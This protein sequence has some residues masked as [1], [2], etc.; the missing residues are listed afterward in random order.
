MGIFCL[1]PHCLDR[2]QTCRWFLPSALSLALGGL[3]FNQ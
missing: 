2:T 1:S 3:G